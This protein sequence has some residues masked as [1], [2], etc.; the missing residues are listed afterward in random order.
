MFWFAL[1][2][3]ACSSTNFFANAPSAEV[4]AYLED[5]SLWGATM[6]DKNKQLR[7]TNQGLL[8]T[9]SRLSAERAVESYT[10]NSGLY[11]PDYVENS[12]LT[13]GGQPDY[14]NHAP[15]VWMHATLVE[16]CSYFFQWNYNECVG[17][18]PD[19]SPAAGTP[20]LYY[21]DWLGEAITCKNDNMEPPYMTLNPAQWML[22]TLQ[23]CCEK[24]FSFAKEGCLEGVVVSG[25]GL[26]Y[27]RS[28]DWI[29]VQDCTLA[30]G[31]CGGIRHSWETSTY[32][33][34]AKCCATIPYD[35]DCNTRFIST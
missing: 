9:V 29:C 15:S 24:N 30:D 33:T 8:R 20:A 13:G 32:A 7:R 26:W 34:R 4:R 14:M 18:A 22:A 1:F 3:L 12:C 17:S 21:P 10:S 6:Q 28:A 35:K 11:Y 23:A 31:A 25:D 19:P 5:M 2:T 16:C 27:K